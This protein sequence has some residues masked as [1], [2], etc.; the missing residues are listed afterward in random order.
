MTMEYGTITGRLVA[1]VA[2]T[3]DDP[4]VNPDIV[5]ITGTVTFTP[6]VKAILVASESV[7]V[8]PVPIVASLDANGYVSLNGVQS[9]TVLATN[10]TYYNP[11]GWTYRVSFDN[12][13]ANGRRVT[14]D[15]YNIEVPVGSTIDLSSV[16]PVT[17]STG[18]PIV[19]GPAGPVGPQG[20]QGNPGPSDTQVA[21]YFTSPSSTRTAADGRYCLKSQTPVNVLDYGADSTGATNSRAAF[22]AAASTGRPVFIPAGNYL[23]DGPGMNTGTPLFIGEDRGVTTITVTAGNYFIDS[24]TAW[25]YLLVKNIKFTGG[26]GA[27]RNAWTGNNVQGQ[28]VVDQCSFQNYS[29]AAISHNG[30]DMPYWK[31]T[32]NIFYAANNTTS[33]GVALNGLTDGCTI[34]DNEFLVNRI[35]VKLGYGGNNAYLSKNDFI[36]FTGTSGTPRVAVW[37]VPAATRI[38]SGAGLVLDRSK[39]GNEGF[40]GAD[41]RIVYADDGGSG[42]FGERQPVFT[43]D[44]SGYISQH[45]I[46]DSLFNGAGTV[47]HGLVYSTT[48][49]IVGLT[50]GPLTIAG[51]SPAYLV[52]FRSQ[53]PDNDPESTDNILGPVTMADRNFSAFSVTNVHNFAKLVD[54]T[55]V[56]ET[57]TGAVHY[58]KSVSAGTNFTNL[59]SQTIRNWTRGGGATATNIADALGGADAVEFDLSNGG[60]A[61]SY[62]TAGALAVGR[63]VWIEFDLKQSSTNPLTS[64]V[65]T[66][67]V[68]SGRFFFRRHIQVPAGWSRYRF[69]TAARS[70]ASVLVK[71]DMEGTGGKVQVGRFRTY[72]G[73]DPVLPEVYLPYATTS[74][75]AP[76]AGGAGAL[77]A[78]PAGYMTVYIGGTPRQIPYY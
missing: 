31:I 10:S 43:A 23:Y 21:T 15:P 64:I 61:Y 63:P 8:V 30:N 62:T 58:T 59:T 5:P 19:R 7:T 22:N 67:G 9:V 73:R 52:E 39:F 40:D 53:L 13:A 25:L 24:N 37:V 70:T 14:F 72:H 60:V 57:N 6:S 71:I 20:P 2:D 4:D 76:S 42:S 56:F 17:G 48:P 34:E 32:R 50:L 36:Q 38:N 51:N 12:L 28:Y 65:L 74:T 29:A 69:Q 35:H 26:A 11:N 77:P 45:V 3:P 44:S 66:F 68:D 18:T 78:T 47:A 55:G 27:I 75:T 54:P 46:K 41:Y 1:A 49:N 16:T 33:M